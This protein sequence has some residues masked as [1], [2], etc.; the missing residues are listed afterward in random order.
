MDCRL[1]SLAITLAIDV[2][3]NIQHGTTP[4]VGNENNYFEAK[5]LKIETKSNY[6]YVINLLAFKLDY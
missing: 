4:R 2:R 1:M 3:T 5:S 6:W